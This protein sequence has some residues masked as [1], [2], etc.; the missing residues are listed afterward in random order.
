MS[1]LFAY[2]S[3]GLQGIFLRNGF[4]VMETAY[5]EAISIHNI[6]GLHSVI[7]LNLVCSQATLSEREIRFL[8]KEMDLSQKHLA[9]ILGVGE[10]SVRNWE[11][12]RVKISGPADK[13]L[14]VLYRDSVEKGEVREI[15]EHLSE[16]NSDAH[17]DRM[18][19]EETDSGWRAQV[20]A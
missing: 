18:E 9:R 10:T 5:G 14:R 20:A 16:L 17:N 7:G 1:E 15:L 2:T 6:E 3:C 12:G 13:M 4:D 19:L 8:R 11:S